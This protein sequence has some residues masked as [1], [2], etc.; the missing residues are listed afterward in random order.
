MTL[1]AL[2]KYASSATTL[3]ISRILTISRVRSDPGVRPSSAEF[4]RVRPHELANS[5]DFDNY[6]FAFYRVERTPSGSL[7]LLHF[8]SI[9]FRR[10]PCT[11]LQVLKIVLPIGTFMIE[12]GDLEARHDHKA[13]R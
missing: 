3:Q 2:S 4:G 9:S 12:R 11:W 1:H 8:S 6:H 7:T 5:A 10:S 13:A